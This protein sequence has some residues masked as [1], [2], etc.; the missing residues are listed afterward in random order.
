MI[1]DYVGADTTEVPTVMRAKFPPIMMA[2]V[3]LAV[4]EG[5]I[6]TPHFF[7]QGLRVNAYADPHVETLQTIVV[8]SPWIYSVANGGGLVSSNK[9]QLHPIKLSKPRIGSMVKNFPHNV[10]SNL[11]PPH[12]SPDLN[13]LDY[14]VWGWAERG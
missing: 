1:G 6:M 3:L 13:S 14:Y 5:H 8:K 7:Q 9:I 2:S 4:R 10:T 11:C 12:N